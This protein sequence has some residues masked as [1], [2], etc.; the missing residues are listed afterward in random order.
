M[1]VMD[2]IMELTHYDP[3]LPVKIKASGEKFIEAVTL[4][5]NGTVVIDDIK[6]SDGGQI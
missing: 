1:T 6:G 4:Q 2:L 3:D 5:N